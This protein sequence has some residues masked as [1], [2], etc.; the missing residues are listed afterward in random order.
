M[1]V[2]ISPL[3]IT[4]PSLVRSAVAWVRIPKGKTAE[5]FN[6][7]KVAFEGLEEIPNSETVGQKIQAGL[8]VNWLPDGPGMEILRTSTWLEI[9]GHPTDRATLRAFY[10]YGILVSTSLIGVKRV[11]SAPR[12]TKGKKEEE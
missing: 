5:W 10:S 12:S 8:K 3:L 7:S 11:A 1:T 9:T 6:M 2:I 4:D